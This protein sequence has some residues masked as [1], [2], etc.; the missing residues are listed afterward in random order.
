[1]GGPPDS[2]ASTDDR[3]DR[4]AATE[5][6]KGCAFP[7][8][9]RPLGSRLRGFRPAGRRSALPIMVDGS[10]DLFPLGGSECGSAC[11][12]GHRSTGGLSSAWC[13][14]TAPL[15]AHRKAL[16]A[17]KKGLCRRRALRPRRSVAGAVA[18][19]RKGT[20][21]PMLVAGRSRSRSR[22]VTDGAPKYADQAVPD[23][24]LAAFHGRG[25][26]HLFRHRSSKRRS[27]PR[28]RSCW[29]SCR[30]RR[31]GQSPTMATP[32]MR[33]ARR[34]GASA[35]SRRSQP[36]FSTILSKNENVLP[37]FRWE[38]KSALDGHRQ[39]TSWTAIWSAARKPPFSRG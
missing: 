4:V 20:S 27:C 29:A 32:A 5:Q 17:R 26:S 38:A 1:M 6:G 35:P 3:G 34:S 18:T 9:L 7:A 16:G 14:S 25:T 37:F 23:P 12:G 30:A 19:A 22:R 15:S 2:Q 39:P 28:P 24:K 8:E 13:S 10:A 11:T 36:C 33:C 31:W 21:W